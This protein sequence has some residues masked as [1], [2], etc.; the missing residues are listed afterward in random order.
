[1]LSLLVGP[2]VKFVVLTMAYI[3]MWNEYG[4]TILNKD[5]FHDIFFIVS[6]YIFLVILINIFTYSK[7]RN[8]L[9]SVLIFG[10]YIKNSVFPVGRHVI[11]EENG[12]D[13]PS[14]GDVPGRA[15]SFEEN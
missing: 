14:N 9:K 7:I 3:E 11:I 4:D 15:R 10:E 2:I 5:N 8:S 6:V 1:M 12:G 13:A